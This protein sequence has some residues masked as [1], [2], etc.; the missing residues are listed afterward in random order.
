MKDI[1]TD[2]RS[3]RTIAKV[4]GLVGK[5]ME[6]D[7]STRFSPYYVRMKIAC[8]DVTK[9]PHSAESTLGLFIHDFIFEREV[10]VEVSGKN[11]KSGIK[12]GDSDSQASP[13]KHKVDPKIGSNINVHNQAGEN[14]RFNRKGADVDNK[15]SQSENIMASAPS[16][17]ETA[18]QRGAKL[19]SDA[20]KV[21]KSQWQDTEEEGRVQIP[22]N[23]DDSESESETF[24]DKLKGIDAY[25]D[26]GQG[27]SKNTD[28]VVDNQIWQVETMQ[29][30]VDPVVVAKKYES[31]VD[32]K[33]MEASCKQQI[34]KVEQSKSGGDNKDPALVSPEVFI[35]DDNIVQTQE[36]L[37]AEEGEEIPGQEML[38]QDDKAKEVEVEIEEKIPEKR[39]SDRLRKE[40]TKTTQER[41]EAMAKKR[42]LEG[43]SPPRNMFSDLSHTSLY[44]MS[45][46]MGIIVD[47]N[48]FK[49]FD[50]LK[51]IESTRLNLFN[52]QQNINRKAYVEEISDAGN[53]SEPLQLEWL[54]ED[55]S[56]PEEFILAQ[57][58]QKKNR[59]RKSTQISSIK[60]RGTKAQEDPGMPKKRG[61]KKK[62]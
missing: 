21:Y 49:S 55:S 5:V 48:S 2:Q 8:R 31:E 12:I 30:G 52:K 36:S 11:L 4:G 13:K 32:Q 25:G 7:E 56:E 9:V 41:F 33:I 40:L 58:K 24:S 15:Q 26:S 10:E 35:P 16:K 54:H 6:I 53:E 3:I 17:L 39:R 37:M 62:S 59:G 57:S 23:F 51:E 34:K 29:I 42:N 44:D 28:Q 60:K 47:D 38:K 46:K 20:Q 27:C 61:R 50:V 19:M 22:E 1:P 14:G 18:K 45:K 43:N